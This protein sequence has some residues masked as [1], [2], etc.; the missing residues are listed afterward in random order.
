MGYNFL[1]DQCGTLFEGR[2]GGVTNAVIGAHTVGFNTGSVGIAL[3]GDFT[4]AHPTAAAETTIAQ[5]AAARLGAYGFSPTS[6]GQMTEGVTGRKWPI[7]TLVT[8]P[9]ISGHK[10]AEQ[11]S[12]GYLTECPGTYL[13]NDL[14]SIRA[15]SVQMITG[16]AGKALAGGIAISGT[17]YVRSAVTITWT[18]DTP[19][20]SIARF[21][22]L[23]DGKVAATVVGTGRSSTVSMTPGNHTIQVRAVHVSGAT[24]VT[25]TYKIVADVTAPAISTAP[26]PNLRTGTYSTTSAPVTVGYKTTDNVRLYTV[27]ATKPATVHLSTTATSWYAT[28]KPGY[29]TTFSLTSRDVPGNTRTVSV[30]RKANLLAESKASRSGSWTTKSSGSYLSGKA[31]SAT[32][33]NAKLTYTFTGRSAA[34][35]F[36]RGSKTG[37]AYIYVDGKKVATVDTKSSKTSYR[38]A[39]WVKSLTAKK[40]TVAVVVVGTSGRPT[41]VSD[42]LAYIS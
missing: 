5:V 22:I 37:Q 8:F 35:L 12:A 6:T 40:H 20:A 33:K 18:V 36:S 32:K 10:D 9:R 21:D 42:G 15:R 7:N 23:R 39:L 25:P 16:L 4:S 11:T 14:A 34:L 31:L 38:Q 17:F 30:V 13:Y 24:G 29:N 1:V 28:M 3:L 41:V 26:T 27:T 2:K 19:S